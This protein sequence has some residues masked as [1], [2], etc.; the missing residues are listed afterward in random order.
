MICTTSHKLLIYLSVIKYENFLL[1]TMTLWVLFCSN[2]HECHFGD[3]R[4]CVMSVITALECE[5]END[6]RPADH[7]MLCPH[8]YCAHAIGWAKLLNRFGRNK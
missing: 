8:I 6:R 5:I 2:Q 7:I 3:P 1:L 4:S